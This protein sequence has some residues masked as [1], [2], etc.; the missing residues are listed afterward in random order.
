MLSEEHGVT[1]GVFL[2]EKISLSL[3]VRTYQINPNQ[4]T[5]N[6]VTVLLALNMSLIKARKDCGPGPDGRTKQT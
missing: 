1:L 6:Q 3:I 4:R 5:S 2:P